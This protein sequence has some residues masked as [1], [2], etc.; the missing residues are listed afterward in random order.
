MATCSNPGCDQPCIN[1]CGACNATPY[2]GPICQT[3]DWAQHKEECPG[4]LLKVGV[5]NLEK[6]KGFY[7]ANNWP[8]VLRYSDI[9]ATKLKQIKDCHVDIISIA[10]SYKH[11]ALNMIDRHKE[12]LECAKEWYCLHLTKHTHP[13]AIRAGFALIES[14]IHN[15]EFFDAVLYARTTWETITLSRDSHIPENKVQWFTAKGAQLLVK[16]TFSLAHSGGISAEEKQA[17]G[18][19]SI[20]LARRALEIHTQLSGLESEQ[21]ASDMGLLADALDFFN[22]VD[23]NEVL[24]LYE[25]AKAIFARQQGSLSPNVA[26]CEKNLAVAYCARADRA[27]KAKDLD[28]SIANLEMALPRLR[29]AVRIFRAINYVDAADTA[30]REL[31][32]KEEQLRQAIA[33]RAAATRG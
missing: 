18:K 22:D 24:R 3:A 7:R 27:R 5:A 29:E 28:R 21:A 6:A 14:C 16:A 26:T 2:C 20:M 12:A 23:D 10:M 17:A 13:Y 1:K 31:V 32:G 9:A 19:E 30:A 25:Q 8:Q 4:H 15:K 11:D 33:L